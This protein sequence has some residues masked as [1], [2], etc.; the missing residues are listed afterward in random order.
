MK[1]LISLILIILI[2]SSYSHSSY[3]QD[4]QNQSFLVYGAYIGGSEYDEI[5]DIAV[6]SDSNFCVTGS[7]RSTD[8]PVKNAFQSESS[9]SHDA[10]VYCSTS[11]GEIIWSTYLGGSISDWGKVITF[12][13]E[14]NVYVAGMT[15]S[16][17]F[18]VLNASYRFISEKGPDGFV[19]SFTYDGKLRWST[20]IGGHHSDVI[21]D[22]VTDNNGNVYIVGTTYS[23]D[24]PL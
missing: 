12:D 10:I 18:P 16:E 7:A 17:D 3:A 9:D 24:F 14:N 22:I 13:S 19:S 23:T 11:D 4:N 2:F 21:N 20:Y 15:N 5:V 8:F 6:D 1:Q